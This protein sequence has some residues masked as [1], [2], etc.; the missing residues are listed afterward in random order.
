MRWNGMRWD[1]MV[2]DGVRWMG[3]YRTYEMGSD[4]TRLD[5]AEQRGMRW[6]GWDVPCPQG[7]AGVRSPSAP[8][9]CRKSQAA[10]PPATLGQ[11]GPQ[12]SQSLLFLNH[13]SSL[14]LIKQVLTSHT[15]QFLP[16]QYY[17]VQHMSACETGRGC[18]PGASAGWLIRTC[19]CCSISKSGLE[20]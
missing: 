13:P 8:A 17:S 6:T 1:G 18:C 4:G 12:G 11:N 10:L 7:R 5:R 14:G 15:E 9:G 3:W 19:Q 20:R 16:G 2:R